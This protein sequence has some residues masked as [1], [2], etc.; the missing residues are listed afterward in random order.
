MVTVERDPIFVRD[1]NIATSAGV[2]AGIDLALALVE[3]DHGH[4]VAM[5]IA[6]QLVVFLKRP[7]GQAQFSATLA[8]QTADRDDVTEIQAYVV[9]HLAADLSVPALA[10][11]AAMSPRHFARVFRQTAGV[12]PARYVERARLEAARRRLEESDV[13]VE[14]IA[15]ECG[16]GSAETM[17]RSF[18]R[19]FHV[20]PAD[21]RR[22]FQP[23]T[24]N[25]EF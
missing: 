24:V 21:Y 13:G 18:V 19:A 25:Q 7:G 9:D 16:F 6:R 2:T 17:R 23:T 10:A 8:A 5:A 12:T 4:G 11:R 20:A 22:R 15:R 3:E 14:G 1:G